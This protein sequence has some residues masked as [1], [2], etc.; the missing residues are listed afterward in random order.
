MGRR[1]TPARAEASGEEPDNLGNGVDRLSG[2]IVRTV[3][4]K[5][6]GFI[7]CGGKDYFFHASGLTNCELGEVKVGS[8]VSFTPSMGAK[9]LRAE[10]VLVQR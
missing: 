10:R 1:D 7:Q 6:F 2:T 8:A 3:L 9:G 5:G 4:D